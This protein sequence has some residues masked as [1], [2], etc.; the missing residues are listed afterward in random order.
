MARCL[1]PPPLYILANFRDI[2]AKKEKDINSRRADECG[3]V[4]GY[5][6]KG[7]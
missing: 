3:M 5:N 7:G 2:P 1:P 6:K 4:D